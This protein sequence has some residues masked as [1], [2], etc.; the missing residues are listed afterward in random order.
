MGAEGCGA[1]GTREL[2]NDGKSLVLGSGGYYTTVNC[3]KCHTVHQMQVSQLQIHATQ[4]RSKGW[5]NKT[6][7]LQVLQ[8]QLH[9]C[10]SAED[11]R[12]SHPCPPGTK[13]YSWLWKHRLQPPRLQSF[14]KGLNSFFD[15]LGGAGVS[16]QERSSLIK[17]TDPKKPSMIPHVHRCHIPV[18]ATWTGIVTYSRQVHQVTLRFKLQS[19]D[20]PTKPLPFLGYKQVCIQ[21]QTPAHLNPDPVLWSGVWFTTEGGAPPPLTMPLTVPSHSRILSLGP[22]VGQGAGWAGVLAAPHRLREHTWHRAM[23]LPSPRNSPHPEP[24]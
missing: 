19:Q 12:F 9:P 18:R 13:T 23:T 6:Q 7:G 15:G 17:D 14:P 1:K 24:V 2:W 8:R 10:L 21:T 3:V 22:S 4:I 11:P 16:L 5:D 20:Q